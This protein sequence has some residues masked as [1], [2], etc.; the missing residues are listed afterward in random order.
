MLK[1][2]YPEIDFVPGIVAG[3]SE[4]YEHALSLMAKHIDAF[5]L[6]PDNTVYSA[7]DAVVKVPKAVIFLFL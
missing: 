1:E 7:I 5:V 2:Q 4:V 6:P 3:S